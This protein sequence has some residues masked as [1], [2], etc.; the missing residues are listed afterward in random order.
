MTF[1]SHAPPRQHFPSSP[2]WARG[3]RQSH[4]HCWLGPCNLPQQ[5]YVV[6]TA[7]LRLAY[8]STMGNCF[9]KPS[10]KN[11]GGEGRPV[12]TSSTPA[13]SKQTSAS[14]KKPTSQGG[15]TLGASSQGNS[16]SSPREAAAKA[17]EVRTYNCSTEPRKSRPRTRGPKRMVATAWI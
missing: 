13:Q 10:D 9:G 4:V 1:D 17:A 5:P 2:L 7:I 16:G 6:R 12:G 11:F 8:L 15:R 3:G 14:S